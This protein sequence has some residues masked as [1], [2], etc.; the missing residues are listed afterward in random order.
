MK[1]FFV[2]LLLFFKTTLAFCQGSPPWQNA[3]IMMQ[4][5]DGINFNSPSIFQDSSGVPCII[6]W[7]SDTLACVFQ[8]FRQPMGS[9]TWDRVAVKFSYNNGLNWTDPIPIIINNL[10]V[11]YQRPFDPTLVVTADKKLRIFFS[12]S[13]GTPIGGLSPEV[14]TYSAISSD[15]IMYDFEAG[16]RFD[17]PANRVID[18]AVT[19]YNGAWH[20]I[21]PIGAPQEGAYYCTS[22]D[23]LV[24]AQ[25]ANI[26]SDNLHNWT[27]NLITDGGLLRF[28]GCGQNIWYNT[29]ADGITWNGYINTNILGGDP[30]VVKLPNG[31]YI[32]V[33]VGLNAVTATSSPSSSLLTVKIY[34]N[35]FTSEI[36]MQGKDNHEYHYSLINSS[37][38]TLAPGYFT[39]TYSLKTGWLPAGTYLLLISDNKKT[40]CTRLIKK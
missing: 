36:T 1:Y 3:L 34:P 14:N 15:G 26:S 30:G 38:A 17:H 16:A 28:Y 29:S 10:P 4:S 18:P 25:G 24:F 37:G 23:G 21:S 8:W 5:N 7:K 9:P 11:N 20:Y 40:C 39:G 31:R 19:T 22:T 12:S 33:Y 6:Q 32:L 13:N 2:I 27:G 35:P